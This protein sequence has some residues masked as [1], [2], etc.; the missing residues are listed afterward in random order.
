MGI[1]SFETVV[2]CALPPSRVF[3][4]VVFNFNELL[5]KAVPHAI[6]SVEVLQGDGGVGTLRKISFHPGFKFTYIKELVE[7]I[8][9]EKL[10]FTYTV[11]EGDVLE[12]KVEK[13]KNDFKVEASPD[14][15]GTILK[16]MSHYY[17]IGDHIMDEEEINNGKEQYVGLFK[18][19]EGYLLA[20][21]DA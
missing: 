1:V 10:T 5:S 12:G 3:K 11:T 4:A 6:K 8:D 13:V 21:P 2:E 18:V 19:I 14:G 16:K 9:E 15:N 17:T 20:N 7:A